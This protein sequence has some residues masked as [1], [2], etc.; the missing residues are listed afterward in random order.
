MQTLKSTSISVGSNV[1]NLVESYPPSKNP[2]FHISTVAIAT[3][4]IAEISEDC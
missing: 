2:M 4:P 1:T 3:R